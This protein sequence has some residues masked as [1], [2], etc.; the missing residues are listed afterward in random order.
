LTTLSR[1]DNA[2]KVIVL[3]FLYESKL[4]NKDKC[5]I[6]LEGADLYK[7]N[8]SFVNLRGAD[9]SGAILRRATLGGANLL[10]D[11]NLSKTDLWG[12]NFN[13]AL[14]GFEDLS[15]IGSGEIL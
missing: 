10:S 4:I 6:A 15:T 11:A 12:A 2:R 13:V 3:K 5:V 9:L 7:I 14:G 8:L 1:L